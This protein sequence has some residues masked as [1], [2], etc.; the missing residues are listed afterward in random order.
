M[1]ICNTPLASRKPVSRQPRSAHHAKMRT[2]EWEAGADTVCSV[3]TDRVGAALCL[4]M[5]CVR[6]GAAARETLLW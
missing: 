6:L 1:T 2:T 5:Q 4:S 3:L